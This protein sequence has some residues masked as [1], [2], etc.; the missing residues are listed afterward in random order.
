MSKK[1]KNTKGYT[2]AIVVLGLTFAVGM[3]T[4]V[5]AGLKGSKG[6]NTPTNTQTALNEAENEPSEDI[7][8][9]S[10]EVLS[11]VVGSDVSLVGTGAS[12]AEEISGGYCKICGR[13]V[14]PT[15]VSCS[16]I[17]YIGGWSLNEGSLSDYTGLSGNDTIRE[18]QNMYI[19][20]CA[21]N[22]PFK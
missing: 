16:Q 11:S 13:A 5:Y 22:Y 2:K 8:E 10:T 1:K 3:S 20:S 17:T 14:T 9:E 18:K 19:F 21:S 12:S 7:T 15:N 4:I 6:T